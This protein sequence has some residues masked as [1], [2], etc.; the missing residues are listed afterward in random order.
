MTKPLTR[1]IIEIISLLT[2]LSPRF[3][4]L[5]YFFAKE[6]RHIRK[7]AETLS[8][9]F[10]PFL[11]SQ[12]KILPARIALICQIGH[13]ETTMLLT[14]FI[15]RG[16]REYPDSIALIFRDETTTY[17]ELAIAVDRLASGLLTLGLKPGDRIALLL[18][19]C[20]P[21]VMS[22]YAAARIGVI[23]VTANPLLKPP[24]LEY[25]WRDADVGLVLTVPQLLP[26]IA[27]VQQNLPNLRHVVCTISLDSLENQEISDKLTGLTGLPE[28]MARGANALAENPLPPPDPK[29]EKECAVIIYTSGTTGHPKGAMLSH[30]NLTMNVEQV[31]D[32][33]NIRA[34]DRFMTIIP[35]FHSFA[36][37]VCMNACLGSGSALILMENFNPARTFEA[38]EKH[39]ATIFCAVPT[40][41]SA[42]LQA[43]ETN[44][45]DLSSLRI[46]VSGGAPLPAATLEKVEAKFGVPVLEGDGPTECSPVTCVNPEFGPRKVGSVGPALID[47]EIAIFDDA[48]NAQPPESIGEIV[49]RGDTVM[50]GYLNQPE[51]T[52][53]VMGN[54]WYHTGDIGK[55]DEDGYIFI[56]DRKK[57]MIITSGFNV[58]PREIE[59]ILYTHP[60]VMEAAVIGLPDALRGEE[61]VAV[62]VRKADA[63]VTERELLSFCR[64]KLANYKIPRRVLFRETLP[65]G[66]TGKIVKRLL[67]KELELEL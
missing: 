43:A 47:V 39:G 55:M 28:L 1:V 49:V 12:A 22:Y 8:Y 51:A 31:R 3:S 23:A 46:F 17:G 35:L 62:I 63:V 16:A 67:K 26:A 34:T 4:S 18:P 29:W 20:P 48:D 57:D 15:D 24:E 2:L 45:H 44:K 56:L 7:K 59:E 50:L 9:R 13:G 38:I 6:N 14:D 10:L 5:P 65:R 66:G 11:L 40:L 41:L 32:R 58:Y 25:M 37:T 53:E 64:D 42:L 54:G 52:A 30:H 61:T 19:N 33:L 27:A 21:F 60:A 36:G